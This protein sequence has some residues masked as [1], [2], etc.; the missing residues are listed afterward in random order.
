MSKTHP[1]ILNCKPSMKPERDW[2]ADHAV[3]AGALKAAAGIPSEVDLRRPWWQIGD[4]GATGSCVGWA[5]ADSVLRWHFVEAGDLDSGELLSPRY[6]WMAA[7][8]RDEFEL[9]PSTFLEAEGTS[10]KAALDVARKFGVVRDKVLPFDKAQLFPGDER[11]FYAI[12]SRPMISSYFNLGT[13]ASEWRRWLALRGPIL[14][15]LDVDATWMNATKT[16]GELKT[17][18]RSSAS[19]GHAVALV[20]YTQNSFIVRNSWGE[21]WGAGGYAFA[22][23]AYASKAFTESYGVVL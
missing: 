14:A 2:L 23:E 5:T 1:R 7:K 21:E 10:L 18:D 22:S 12:A 19:G 3:A 4:Q 17:Y 15:R 9:R 20:G 6:V 13:K 11:E 8:E 16:K